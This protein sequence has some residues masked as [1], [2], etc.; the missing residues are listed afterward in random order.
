MPQIR[1]V[2]TTYEPFSQEPESIETNRAFI[3]A[4]PLAPDAWIL[5]LACGTGLLSQMLKEAAPDGFLAGIDLD[6]EQIELSAK[7][8]R[9]LG[10]PVS[11]DAA[12]P[13]TRTG[14]HPTSFAVGDASRLDFPPRVFDC[15]TMANAIHMV[16][17]KEPLIREVSRVL[18]PGGVFGFNSSFYAGTFVEGTHAFYEE[19]LKEAHGQLQQLNRERAARGEPPH[20][21]VRGKSHRAAQNRW[22]SVEEWT[23]LLAAHGLRVHRCR[24]RVVQLNARCFMAIGAYGGL[25]KVLM[26][27]YPVEIAS[28]VLQAAVEPALAAVGHTA[29]PRNWLEIWATRE[30]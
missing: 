16:M 4:Q 14:P 29:I 17:D 12:L 15:V 9:E 19:W 22:L 30:P 26:S 10:H 2:N 25:A 20:A 3:A 27:G 23:G 13:A 8:F 7:R 28:Q 24:E 1:P 18:K 11:R 6:P 21:R 5:D